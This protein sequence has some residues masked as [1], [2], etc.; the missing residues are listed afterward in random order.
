MAVVSGTQR[1]TVCVGVCCRGLV[2]AVVLVALVSAQLRVASVSTGQF[3]A[4]EVVAFIEGDGVE[5]ATGSF[6]HLFA[7]SRA[8][9]AAHVVSLCLQV[10]CS[11]LVSSVF[12]MVSVGWLQQACEVHSRCGGL[13]SC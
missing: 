4:E 5:C 6:G 3:G 13:V 10:V 2:P 8:S 11:A 1:A 9:C 12:L 7:Y